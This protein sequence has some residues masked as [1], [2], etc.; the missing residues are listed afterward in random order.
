MYM[1]LYQS[2]IELRHYCITRQEGILNRGIYIKNFKGLYFTLDLKPVFPIGVCRTLF[3]PSSCT[4]NTMDT[5]Y[6][7]VI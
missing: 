3:L 7:I 4:G 6:V 1:Y 2:N 5:H